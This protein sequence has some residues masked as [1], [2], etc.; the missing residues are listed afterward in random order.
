MGIL[1]SIVY[2]TD[3]IRN[4]GRLY[5]I[6]QKKISPLVEVIRKIIREEHREVNLQ[7]TSPQIQLLLFL[8]EEGPLMMSEIAARLEITLGGVTAL[9]NRMDKTN[10]IERK[11]SNEDRRVVKLVITDEGKSLLDKLTKARNKTI[12]K[13]F[14]KLSADEVKELERL[15][16]K[17]LD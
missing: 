16:R 2:K 5:H 6:A 3:S 9:A 7:L 13:Y 14:S 17:M 10:L 4:R 15:C 12:E 1:F 8:E 11:R